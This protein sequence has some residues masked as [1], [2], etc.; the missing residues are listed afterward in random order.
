MAEIKAAGG[1]T[2]AQK[3][4]QA[5]VDGMPRAAIATGS[6][7][8][9]LPVEDIAAQLVRLARHPFYAGIDPPER[10]APADTAHIQRA[11]RL[12]RRA[13]GIDFTGYKL[14]TLKRRIERRMALHP[15]VGHRRL[16]GR[17]GARRGR[18]ATAEDESA[19]HVTAFFREPASYDALSQVVFPRLV[20]HPHDEAPLRFWVPGCSTGEETYSLAIAVLE[21]LGDRAGGVPLQIFGTDVS[22]AM[23]DKA[24]AGIYPAGIAADVSRERLRRFFTKFDGG[25]R[26]NKEI[27]DRCV[28]AQQDV[29]RDPPFSKQDLIV[30]RN[31]LIYLN[32]PVQ[33][34]VLGV[35]HYAL[36]PEGVLML[37]RSETV[38]SQAELFSAIDKKFQLYGKKL[39]GGRPEVS[40]GL[41]DPPRPSTSPAKK[42]AGAPPAAYA[43]WMRK[44]TRI[45][46]C[47][48]ATPPPP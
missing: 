33:R 29:T 2:M 25:Y 7:D 22:E 36:R 30:C 18:A 32:Q 44:P 6:V 35:F 43:A 26:I 13:S 14:P 3:P 4:E 37:G 31:L 42:A 27:R 41:A 20:A 38:G 47:S 1:I 11:F 17:A 10:D 23:I 15:H 12:L 5:A 45:D 28:F 34:K 24:R 8:S 39:T 16:R 21:F 46:S 19:H 40:F 9:V 48:I